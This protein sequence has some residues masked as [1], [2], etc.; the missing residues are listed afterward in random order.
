[1]HFLLITI[2]YEG[3]NVEWDAIFKGDYG[4]YATLGG[5]V[6]NYNYVG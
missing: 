6:I 4:N 2:N 1:M 5:V 3:T